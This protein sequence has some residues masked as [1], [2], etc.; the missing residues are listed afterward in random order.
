MTKPRALAPG[1]LVGLVAPASPCQDPER[2]AASVAAL[3]GL[4]FRVLVGQSCRESRGYL[5]GPDQARARDIEAFFADPSVSAIVCLK[6]GYGSP[7]ILDLVDW[8]IAAAHPKILLGYSDVTALHLALGRVGL[9]GIHAPMPSSDMLPSLDPFSRASWLRA[10]TSRLPLGL[11]EPPPGQAAPV[12]LAGGRAS[13]PLVGGN[14]SLVAALMGTPWELDTR[15]AI[16]FLEDVG[17]QPYRLDRMLSQLRLAGKFRDCAGIVLGGFTRCE[18][19]KDK[20]SLSLREVFEDI[21]LPAGRPCIMG[22]A[23]GH[24]IPSHSLPLGVEAELDADSGR[25]AITEAAL[26]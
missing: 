9:V 19:A 26:T 11:L 3:E 12:A 15:G 21:L 13:G 6:G 5:A 23:A 7:R 24:C 18:P 2:L 20:P 22:F 8:G 16:L 25:L 4:G 1:D 14:L 10:V 17:E